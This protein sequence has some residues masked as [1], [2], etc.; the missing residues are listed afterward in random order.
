M[1]I[2]T[3]F[4]QFV[5]KTVGMAESIDGHLSTREM[6]FLCLAAVANNASGE[7]L[8]IGSFLGRSTV[9]LAKCAEF[10]G[11]ERVVAVDPLTLPAETDPHMDR[12]ELLPERFRENLRRCGV[13]STVEFHQM[14]S[15]ELG[16]RWDRPIRLL[17]IDGDHTLRGTRNDLDT[18]LPHLSPGAIV[19]MH[20]VLHGYEGPLH[21]MCDFVLQSDAFG[22]CGV[23]GS[24]GWGRFLGG[25]VVTPEWRDRKARLHRSLRRLIDHVDPNLPRCGKGLAFRIKRALVP[26]GD[27]APTEWVGLMAPAP[28]SPPRPPI[29]SS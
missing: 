16:R 8:E 24:I 28:S 18:F 20:D 9:L 10:V 15:H 29:R 25:E 21:A 1:T 2:P 13:D 19:A 22:A 6:R 27:I 5:T 23:C 26:H 14:S 7:V 3:G 11:T 4:D 17:W 12:R